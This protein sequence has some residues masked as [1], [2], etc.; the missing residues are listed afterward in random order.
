[1]AVFGS[2]APPGERSR[3]RAGLAALPALLAFPFAP[4]LIQHGAALGEY[5]RSARRI[6]ELARAGGVPDERAAA[7]ASMVGELARAPAVVQ[8][9]LAA[10]PESAPAR[11]LAARLSEDG[12]RVAAWDRLLEVR[13]HSSEAWEQGAMAC[14]RAGR[15]DEA[16]PRLAGALALS[17][18][19]PR[20]LKN[21]TRLELEHGALEAGLDALSR[22]RQEGCED[23]AWTLALGNE[24]VLELG[25]PER[26][27][28]V[29]FGAPLASLSAEDLHARSREPGEAAHAEAAECLAQLLWARGH[30]LAGA[31]DVALRNY[32][33]AAERS[34]ARRGSRIGPAPLYAFELAAAAQL[35]GRREEAVSR[36]RG[37]ALGQTT[38][39]DLPGW[40]R[41]ALGELGLRP[42]S[43]AP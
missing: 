2:L 8:V 41:A 15:F 17:P 6:D 42:P 32:R 18:T 34:T 35:A 16:R 30:A 1:M 5:T 33:Q 26:G 39:D 37:V 20:L 24:L 22:L 3:L 14:V 21:R 10:A 11:G 13:P 38:W 31:F 4:A 9:A 12:E 27:A 25:R 40:A 19:H 7:A 43:R 29:L 28:R 36:T 23:P